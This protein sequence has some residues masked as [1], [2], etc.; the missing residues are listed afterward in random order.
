MKRLVKIAVAVAVVALTGCAA[1]HHEAPAQ[2]LTDAQMNK[3]AVAAM[4]SGGPIISH[5]PSLAAYSLSGYG[6]PAPK[7]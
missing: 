3:N 2:K 5:T 4:D 7:Q 1:H 6:K